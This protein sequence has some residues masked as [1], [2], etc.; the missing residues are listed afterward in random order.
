MHKSESIDGVSMTEDSIVEWLRGE[1]AGHLSIE[2][3][4]LDPDSDL[5][6][7][8]L[9]SSDAVETA[10]ALGQWL[11]LDIDPSLMWEHQTIRA[12]AQAVVVN[13]TL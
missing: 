13:G 1:I 3:S 7:Y 9:D 5:A 6:L 8:S 2:V 12:M 4:Q 10:I 11:K